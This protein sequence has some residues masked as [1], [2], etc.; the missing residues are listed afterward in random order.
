MATPTE[1]IQ[2][3]YLAYYNRPGD[4]A[5][6]N[7]WVN[8]LNSGTS[9]ATISKEFAKAPEY[10]ATYGGK[11][12]DAVVATIYQ[13]L[14][15]RLPDSTGLNYWS[16]LLSRKVLTIDNI[17]ESVAA[18]AQQ[19]PAK[20]PDTIA[21]QSKVAAAVAFTDYLNTDVAARVAYSTGS[22]N[23][24]ATQYLAG[25]T[26]DATL[27]AA[28]AGLAATGSAIIDGGAGV[29]T[30]T[31]LTIAVDT[32]AGTAANDTF[33]ALSINPTTG[34]AATTLGAF[35]V[36]DGGAGKDTLNIYADGTVNL[37]QQGTV[38]NVE[39][40]NIYNE[41]TTAATQFGEAAGVNAAGFVGATAVWQNGQANKIVGVGATTTAGFR[42]ISDAALDVTASTAGVTIALADVAGDAAANV[43]TLAVGGS[44]LTSVTV[45]GALADNAAYAGSDAASLALTAT[46]AEDATTF[47]LN[48][49]VTTTLVV[50]DT[51]STK[52]VAT[53]NASASSGDITFVG[54]TDVATITTGSGDD[55]VEIAT[56]LTATVKAASL[57]TGAGDDSITVSITALAAGTAAVNAGAGDDEI[58]LTIATDV[59]YNVTG[60]EGD[61]VIAVTGT[62]KT[63]DV[64]DGGAGTDTIAI[65][66]KAT[67][68]AD[69]YIVYTK[70]LKNFESLNFTTTAVGTAFTSGANLDASKLTQ[71]KEF[72]FDQGGF[73]SAVAAD[74]SLV[75]AA[76]LSARASG[77]VPSTTAASSTTYAGTLD[78]TAVS[79]ATVTVG[80]N[81][82]KLNVVG[83]TGAG[84]ADTAATLTGDAKT[85]T[86]TLTHGVDTS[87]DSFTIATLN[88]TTVDTAS[89]AS[90]TGLEALTTLT[91]T[92]N[93]VANVTNANGTKLATVDASALASVDAAGDATT[94]LV[95]TS[96]NTGVETIKL[97]AGVDEITLTASTYGA[98]DTVTGLHLVLDAAGTA[99][100]V[101]VS[102]QLTVG[103]AGAF[104]KFTTTQTDFDLAL[105]DA[106]A[107]SVGNNLVFKFGSDTYVFVD[108]GTAGSIDAADTVVK[109]TGT[110]D[111]DTL[112]IALATV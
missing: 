10:T 70:V 92:G 65:D 3:L 45:S 52:K 112:I 73:V 90:P 66:G 74:Q 26:N 56:E 31:A 14:F 77:Y 39:T 42:T 104:L 19:D 109:L 63:T 100:D 46:V 94:G 98:V 71:Y 69:D 4:V 15:N 89:T 8:A 72:V 51:A 32:P 29:G 57:T 47:T 88:L 84:A 76:A 60:G 24:I 7:F 49:A 75:T 99:L 58:D 91:L 85:A 61:D 17:V 80:A 107:S 81:D 37:T 27:T 102:D 40:I 44:K 28:K 93:G 16:D 35:D 11:T 36:I 103:A 105:K 21:I 96:A 83:H 34:V 68:V 97:G 86:V 1:Q 41:G 9:L 12:P 64:I 79:N 50:T 33:N 59:T 6:V 87:D 20:G 111:L 5:G 25:V 108:A 78:V 22:A 48:S 95:Y 30:T 2:Q 67:Y 54:D 38:K 55:A 13:N 101:G 18:S 110:V 106:A 23:G 53:V 62:V 43:S 82:V